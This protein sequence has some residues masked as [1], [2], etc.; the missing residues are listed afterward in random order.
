MGRAKR[1]RIAKQRKSREKRNLIRLKMGKRIFFNLTQCNKKLSGISNRVCYKSNMHDLV[2]KNGHFNNVRYRSSII[3]KCNFN[4]AVLNCVDFCNCNLKNTSFK[5]AVLKNVCFSIC[6]LSGV[7][8]T[9]AKFEN[10]YFICTDIEKAKGIPS[11]TAFK[12][13]RSYPQINI[14][15]GI[16]TVLIQLAKIQTLFDARVIHV[17]KSKLNM[18]TI[19]IL[20]DLYGSNGLDALLELREEKKSCKFYTVGSL[21]E[22]IEKSAN[23]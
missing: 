1:K 3:T 4:D 13:Y 23:M 18:W 9:N 2:Y 21:I 5:N 6:N 7:D 8:F 20:I 15:E 19:K 14:D 22:Y 11:D 10:V 17:S 16:Q 12:I